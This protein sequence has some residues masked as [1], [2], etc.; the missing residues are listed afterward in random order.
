MTIRYRHPGTSGNNG[1]STDTSVTLTLPAGTTAGDFAACALRVGTTG[2]T[3]SQ[4][5]GTGAWTIQ[6][7]A[8]DP[9]GGYSWM[10]AWRVLQ[11]GDTAPAF[12]W[13]T[14]GRHCWSCSSFYSDVQGVLS[15]DLFAPADPV[16][17]GSGGTTVT[18]NP[19]TASGAGEASVIFTCARGTATSTPGTHTYTPPS[20]W[21]WD[22]GDNAWFAAGLNPRFAATCY[23]L[24]VSGTVTP[25]AETL[26]DDAGDVFFF[27]AMHA[28][29]AETGGVV[30]PVPRRSAS[31][32]LAVTVS[33]SGWRNGHSW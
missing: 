1:A 21:T 28:V 25:G 20:G 24:L 4:A 7:Q 15:L 11:P 19:L 16:N 31:R 10:V 26:T 8:S 12:G 9:A 6:Q 33:S 5:G 30:L 29:I 13:G 2:L 32:P 18:P 27:T 23:R 17:T 22:D 3:F 14:A